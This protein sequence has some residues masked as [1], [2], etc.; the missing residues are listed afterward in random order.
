[1]GSVGRIDVSFPGCYM[2]SVEARGCRGIVGHR[3]CYRAAGGFVHFVDSTH[4]NRLAIIRFDLLHQVSIAIIHELRRLPTD[5]YGDQ[6][7]FGIEGVALSLSK[8]LGI[9]YTCLYARNHVAIQSTI[10]ILL[11]YSHLNFAIT[12]RSLNC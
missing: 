7:I 4:V 12:A 11:V 9:S 8:W 2:D 6:A 10:N 3:G 5:G 1:M